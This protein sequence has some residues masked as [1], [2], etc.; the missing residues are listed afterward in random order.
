MK[1]FFWFLAGMLAMVSFVS[2]EEEVNNGETEE[3]LRL[4]AYMSIHYPNLQPSATGLYSI[5]HEQ[6]EG[7]AP[8][9]DD[10]VLYNYTAMNLDGVVFETNV[11]ST[12]YLN[13]IYTATTRYVP[14]YKLF[15][16]INLI[17]GL[18]EGISQLKPPAKARFIMPSSLA[19]GGG[20]HKGQGPYASI[21]I[22]IELE[23]VVKDPEA[24]ETEIIENFLTDY[25][26]FGI[27]DTIMRDSVYYLEVNEGLGD[28]FVKDN[29]VK[30]NYVGR[31]IDGYVFDTNIESVA[32]ENGLYQSGS[33]YIPKEMIVESTEL[34]EGFSLVLKRLRREGSAT[35]LIRSNKAYG[36]TGS[37][38]IRPYEPLIFDITVVTEYDEEDDNGDDDGADE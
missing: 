4:E 27:Q 11:Y 35:V 3:L 29:M 28:Y 20:L 12:A 5:I 17:A 22:D 34:I 2:C 25:F 30:V 21:I 9:E 23:E 7:E 6:G 10:Y 1:R 32:I 37:G 8:Q 16:E 26:P 31:F 24:Q 19:W 13:N 15:N 14:N 18:Y 38:N 33:S 36:A